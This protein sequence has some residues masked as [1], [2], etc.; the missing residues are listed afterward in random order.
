MKKIQIT[1]TAY[2]VTSDLAVEDIQIVAQHAPDKLRIKDED[3]NDVFAVGFNNGHQVVSKYGFTFGGRNA[4]GL[5]TFTSM[6]PAG[7]E[8]PKVFIADQLCGVVSHLETL[9]QSIPATATEVRAEQARIE[10]Q[11]QATRER[12]IEL[13]EVA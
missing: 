13:I 1:G 11:M 6:I 10:E 7:T 12:L 8:D 2:T 3:G 4:E 5:A 9:E